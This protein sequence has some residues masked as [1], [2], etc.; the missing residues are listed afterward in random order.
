[1]TKPSFMKRL[2]GE[3]S[4]AT[5]IEYALIVTILS[6]TI[7]SGTSNIGSSASALF[8]FLDTNVGDVGAGM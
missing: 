7:I 2:K 4:G 8:D 3:I 5:S 1:M 6:I